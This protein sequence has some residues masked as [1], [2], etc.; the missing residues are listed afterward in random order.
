MLKLEVG[1]PF[2]QAKFYSVKADQAATGF[3]IA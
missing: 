1:K 3:N 2:K